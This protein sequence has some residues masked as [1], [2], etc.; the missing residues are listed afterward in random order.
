M[1]LDLNRVKRTDSWAITADESTP[2]IER[3]KS[4]LMEGPGTVVVWEDLDR[5][6]PERYAESGWGRRRLTSLADKTADHL[7]MV[8]HRFLEGSV[9]D[10][11]DLVHHGERREAPPLEPVRA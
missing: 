8:F 6:L 11:A 2:A 9:P 7:A 1:T 3:A 5:A 4:I 10:R